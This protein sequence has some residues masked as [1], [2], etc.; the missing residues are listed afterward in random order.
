VIHSYHESLP[1]TKQLLMGVDKFE[2][3]YKGKSNF[4]IE[5]IDYIRLKKKMDP[6]IWELYLKN[7]YKS[8]KF[9][10]IFVDTIYPGKQLHTI[11]NKQYPNTPVVYRSNIKIK[12]KKNIITLN[13]TEM[14]NVKKTLQ[15]A[16]M[17]N[18]KLKNVYLIKAAKGAEFIEN[19]LLQ[20]LN[21]TA[22]KL[23]I[24]ENYSIEELKKKVSKLPED[25]VVFYILNFKD[26]DGKRFVPKEFIQEI[27]QN[28]NAPIYSFW[29]SYMGS[30]TIG[31]YMF[32]GEL[33]AHESLTSLLKYINYS[34]K[35]YYIN[36]SKFF[37]DYEVLVRYGIDE[38]K[39]P[40]DTVFIN[41][42]IPIWVSYPKETI[43]AI[44][45]IVLLSLL[46]LLTF[47]LKIRNER[48]LKMEEHMFIQSKQAAMGDMISV[49]AHQWRQPLN[50]ISIM[51]QT[52][53]LKY[54][55]NK[56][57][58]LMMIKFKTDILKQ[59]QY[60]SKIVDDFKFFYKPNKE[61][62]VFDIKDE[63]VKTI[64]L[65]KI[66]YAKDGI[67]IEQHTQDSYE[68]CGYENEL[69]HCFLVILQNAQ[70]ALKKST[71][72]QKRII[73]E[74]KIKN[75]EFT[76][77]FYNNG[78]LI[79]KEIK[80][81]I[82]KPYFSTKNEKNGTGIGL[83]MAQTIIEKHFNGTIKTSNTKKGVLF[84]IKISK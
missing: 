76:V 2:K 53:L 36:N 74:S 79:P 71:S 17:H 70:D 49:I 15:L 11:L 4:F 14:S 67:E 30:G 8:I 5:T 27:A 20:E 32:D 25:S 66:A 22:Y 80:E 45:T 43:F 28:S 61:K 69:T 24:L 59:I 7:K 9:D 77:S 1:W 82:F 6:K 42:P 63:L 64:E 55:K 3:E 44:S 21:K 65:I 68:I 13:S 50:S 10:G 54:K 39:N 73:I 48:I 18:P 40:K 46:L 33:S 38:N 56:L 60:M 47:I 78:E 35:D 41:K 51:V 26:K 58:E 16:V 62:R 19:G 84:E 52:I 37:I 23:T 12:N 83:Y 75:D 31:G 57:D 81:K 34:E 29:S 72:N